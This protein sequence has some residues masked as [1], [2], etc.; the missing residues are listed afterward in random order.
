[1]CSWTSETSSLVNSIR[2]F[3]IGSSR[4]VNT[5]HGRSYGH[6]PARAGGPTVRRR[7]HRQGAHAGH[8]GA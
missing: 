8:E 4:C 3:A 6:F 2:S 7:A 1:M 5:Q